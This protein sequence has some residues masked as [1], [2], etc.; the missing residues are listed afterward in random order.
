MLCHGKLCQGYYKVSSDALPNSLPLSLSRSVF[1][2]VYLCQPVLSL[3]LFLRQEKKE[4]DK[5]LHE[6]IDHYREEASSL[7][8]DNAKVAA[9]VSVVYTRN[10]SC[11]A[12]QLIC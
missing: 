5:I 4:N 11:H 8:L 6:Q 7:R 12:R 1:L 9:K 2:C 10:L 3:S